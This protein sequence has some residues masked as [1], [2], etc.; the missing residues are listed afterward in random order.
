M[1]YGLTHEAMQIRRKHMTSLV[2]RATSLQ[3]P[4]LPLS[5]SYKLIAASSPHPLTS[6]SPPGARRPWSWWWGRSLVSSSSDSGC[7]Q[8]SS[9][10]T[11]PGSP[12][13]QTGVWDTQAVCGIFI[14]AVKKG[15]IRTVHPPIHT[16][17]QT[18]VYRNVKVMKAS[19]KLN[20][21]INIQQTSTP[22]INTT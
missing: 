14:E 8:R 18:L 2:S 22:R 5:S 7:T 11:R 9:E 15:V 10:R 21:L 6:A 4:F 3:G 12:P 20:K 13:E 16:L 1:K 19:H 17:S